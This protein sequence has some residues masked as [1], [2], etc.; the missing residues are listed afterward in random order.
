[1]GIAM[2]V[3][4]DAE[5]IP[6]A[7]RADVVHAMVAE[8]FSPVDIEFAAARGPVAANFVLT[9]LGDLSVCSSVSSA[10]TLRRTA[11]LVRDDSTPSIFLALQM[12]DSSTVVAQHGRQVLLR[13]G[14]L[15][16]YDSASPWVMFDDNGIRQHKIR[17]PLDRMTLPGRMI[18]QASAVTLCPGHPIAA[19]AA[20][21]FYRLCADPEAFGHRGGAAVSQPSVELLRAVISTHLGADAQS[22]DSLQATL[23]LRIMEYLR[24]HLREPE[25]SAGRIAAAHHISVRLLYRILAAEGIS[26]REW[27]RTQRLQGCRTDLTATGEPIAAVA[28]RWGFTNASS[29]ARLFRAEFGM[30]PREWR[31]GR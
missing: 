28:R 25:L 17:I 2:T 12:T 18:E 9:D 13:P 3:T 26:L 20:D 29:F 14:D 27:I 11:A 8:G 30:S 1:M 22:E 21:Y 5:T 31:E 15:V 19:L 7:D 6:E 16:V 24:A 10:V 23:T 4:F